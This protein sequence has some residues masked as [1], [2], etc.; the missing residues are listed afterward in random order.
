MTPNK[1]L[2]YLFGLIAVFIIIIPMLVLVSFGYRV[3][4]K[5]HLVKTGGIYLANK[6]LDAVVRLNGKNVKKTG[7][8]ERSVLIRNLMPK[9][10]SVEVEKEG[11]RLWKKNVKV[12]EQ[13]VE[14]CFPLLVQSELNAQPVPKYLIKPDEKIKKKREP[15]EEYSEAQKLFK[16]HD[17]PVK[18]VIPGWEN[19]TVK[20]KL[21]TNRR[22][23][24][25]VLLI[26]QDNKIYAQWIGT[27]QKR[28]F[29]IDT[30][31]KKMVYS[32]DKNILSF[33]FFPGRSDAIL[34][35]LEDL[36]L[37]AV[38]IDTRFEIHNIYKLVSN[39]SKFA[40]RDE[41][42]YY[43]SGKDMFKIDFEP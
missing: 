23:N 25:K 18:R 16:P 41:F 32:P 29:F 28:P 12:E 2:V 39:C 8:F 3:N 33:G 24:S 22:L 26:R 30:S 15:N 10:Y 43:F 36:N 21:G 40:V 20:Y 42:L 37:Y 17:K 6:E 9:T 13:L 4:S 5:F 27:D 38:E 14:V 7:M 1:K 35:L 19:D 11:Y 34:V 31:G